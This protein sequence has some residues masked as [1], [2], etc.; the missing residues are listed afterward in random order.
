MK[1][2]LPLS[3]DDFGLF[4]ELLIETS[5]LFFEE[6]R[7]QSLHLALWQR[8]QH[9][10]YDSYREYYNLLKF[11]PEGRLEMRE[12]LDLITI[13]E[14]YFFRNKPQ[15]DVLM[16]FVLPE[17]IQR[18]VDSGDKCIRVWSA[19]C[20]RGD[21][22]Y[23]IAIA[24]MEVIPSREEW[25]ISIL[26]TDINRK[27]LACSAEAIYGQKD[28]GHLEKETLEKY[29][30]IQGST[31]LLRN[32]VKEGVRFEYHNLAKDPFIHKGMQH[33]DI[34]FCRN[35]IIY[36]HSQTTQRVIESFHNC[37]AQDGYLFLGHT[38]TLWQITNKLERVEF[39]QTFIYKKTLSPVQEDA[40]KPF[41]AVPE[42]NA[43][44]LTLSAAPT[45]GFEAEVKN[46]CSGPTLSGP[47]PSGWGAEGLISI[48]ETGTE[49]RIFPQGVRSGLQ[50]KPEPRE[51]IEKPPEVRGKV[52]SAYKEA[53]LCLEEMKDKASLASPNH[54]IEKGKNHVR[55]YLTRATILANEAK[56][57]EAADILE[58]IIEADNLTVEAY[59]LLGVLSYKSGNLK[60]AETQFKKVI[61]VDP[62]LVLAYFNLGNMYLYRRKFR[63]AAREFRNAIRLLEKR[64]KDEQVRFCE[65]FT[66]E[67]LLR[68]CRNSLI[69]ISKRGE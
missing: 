56:Y 39:P 46:R 16:R 20:S 67:F 57:K 65:D 41:M 55:T 52:E 38:E 4:Q 10:G 8:L 51:E 53:A 22:A 64:P 61:Y 7:S 28:I 18:K 3:A 34:I 44:N 42:I 30:K 47:P 24:I 21:E 27:G 49:E 60:E 59:Y 31:Y 2:I 23:S 32:D 40:T 5:G 15:F 29:F 58:K 26:G 43:E 36:F 66:V 25:R 35:V 19:G 12:L 33:I 14:T 37:L 62:N 45:G 6:S 11:H 17:I 13:G 1:N 54:M 68:A 50:E 63:E 9:R 48:K 69:E